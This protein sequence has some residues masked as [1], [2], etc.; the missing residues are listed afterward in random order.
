M[1]FVV[2]KVALAEVFLQV[3]WLSSVWIIPPGFHTLISS[4]VKIVGLLVAAV[5][6]YFHRHEEQLSQNV[7][8]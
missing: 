1:E 4:G 7:C 3:S 8:I 2:H 6:A 5:Q